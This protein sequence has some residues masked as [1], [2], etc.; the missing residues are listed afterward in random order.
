VIVNC[1]GEFNSGGGRRKG[2]K[3]EKGSRKRE[4]KGRV[5]RGEGKGFYSFSLVSLG[6]SGKAA[7]STVH[8]AISIVR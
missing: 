8:T 2:K 5:E 4:G 1:K 6:T 3:K 7:T